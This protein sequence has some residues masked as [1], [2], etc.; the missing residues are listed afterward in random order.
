MPVGSEWPLVGPV[1]ASVKVPVHHVH[2][3]LRIDAT[4]VNVSRKED[5]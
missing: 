4:I 5:W 1:P 3:T 2:V